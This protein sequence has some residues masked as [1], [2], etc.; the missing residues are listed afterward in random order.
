M[1]FE[2]DF[3]L[4]TKV[5]SIKSAAWSQ[6]QG[7]WYI[8]REGFNLNEV[9]EAMKDVAWLDYSALKKN[10]S[11]D[12]KEVAKKKPD[13]KSQVIIPQAYTDLLDQKRYAENTKAIYLSYFA[14]FVRDFEKRDLKEIPKEEIN[15]YILELI[16]EKKISISQQNQRINAIK[17]YYEKVLRRPTEYYDIERPRQEKRLP[18]VLSKTEIGKIIDSIDNLKH[19][20][21][22]STIYS[23]GLR[24]SEVLNLKLEQIDSERMMIKICGAKGKK[25]RY[26]LLSQKLLILLREYFTAYKPVE[27]LFEGQTGGVYSAESV[28][29]ILHRAVKKSG[30]KKYVTPHTL[31]H[32]FAT[33][34]LEQG[35]DL[36]YI[37][38]LLGHESSKTTEIYTHVSKKELGKIINPLDDFG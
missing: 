18:S 20:A 21:I 4:I 22:I 31:R 2:N 19:K 8:P 17:F 36:R 32:S 38:E 25:D 15:N 26:T 5:K 11:D 29:K 28:S 30:I 16:R 9:F 6:S 33:H 7:Y 24:R 3:G 37:Q 14:D 27:W 35:V 10:E 23:A 1:R 13:T 12:H 34:L